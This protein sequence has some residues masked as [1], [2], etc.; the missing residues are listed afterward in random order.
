MTLY[1]SVSIITEDISKVFNSYIKNLQISQRE[2]I[3]EIYF[4][5]LES[6]DKL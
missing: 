6:R 5:T 3:W 4:M 2:T 1:T